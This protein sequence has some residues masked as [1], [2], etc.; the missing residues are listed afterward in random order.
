MVGVQQL[1]MGAQALKPL[2]PSTKVPKGGKS[3]G[4]TLSIDELLAA[5]AT[6][7][8]TS[9]D[10]T[11]RAELPVAASPSQAARAEAAAAR[12][13]L[14]KSVVGSSKA[15]QVPVSQAVMTA[16]DKENAP[17]CN[18]PA[19]VRTAGKAGRSPRRARR[20]LGGGLARATQPKQPAQRPRAP[21]H[22]Q[23]SQP[24]RLVAEAPSLAAG[25]EFFDADEDGDDADASESSLA[26]PLPR[27]TPIPAR[28]KPPEASVARTTKATTT[29]AATT[30]PPLPDE[31][32]TTPPPVMTDNGSAETASPL[33]APQEPQ[34]PQ[35]QAAYW[36]AEL[37][38]YL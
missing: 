4:F 8:K 35:G 11:T 25:I 34:E 17:A 26:A 1:Q 38:Q 20:E 14:R 15:A 18:S 10:K 13:R 24:W 9:D 37:M 6:L 36:C 30:S 12:S 27:H 22:P 19:K 16:T 28:P 5:T 2:S 23:R 29:A 32:P 31:R 3:V 33:K 21:P 7:R